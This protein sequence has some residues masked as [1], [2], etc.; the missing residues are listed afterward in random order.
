LNSHHEV[1]S[2]TQTPPA[3]VA[4]PPARSDSIFVPRGLDIVVELLAPIS[5]KTARI[6]DTFTFRTVKPL[7]VDHRI[8]VPDGST[9]IGLVSDAVTAGAH[10]KGGYLFL[11]A[12]SI[13]LRN[14]QR[15]QVAID[16]RAKTLADHAN[17][18]SMPWFGRFVPL[19]MLG[20]AFGAFSY[21]RP[22][23]DVAY[24]S[25]ATFAVCTV[26]DAMVVVRQR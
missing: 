24:Q 23:K 21:V 15:L 25:G 18:L 4:S 2:P 12:R 1:I 9:G 16:H 17:E 8:V 26:E 20:T 6:G 22:G 13:E 14:G 7:I 5:S 19:P 10:S 11:E 3:F